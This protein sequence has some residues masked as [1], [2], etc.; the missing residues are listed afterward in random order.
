MK[1]DLHSLVTL[2]AGDHLK[3]SLEQ[4]I[5]NTLSFLCSI[6]GVLSV[7]Q[8]L[9]LKLDPM[10]VIL[11]AVGMVLLTTY[12]ILSRIKKIFKPLVWPLIL[13]STILI[14]AIW[15]YN[16]GSWGA[17]LLLFMVMM[18]FFVVITNG[19][20][21]VIAVIWTMAVPLF[22]LYLEYLHP[23]I[24]IS[25]ESPQVRYFDLASTF[26]IVMGILGVGTAQILT[27][28]RRER[29]KTEDQ[30]E[31]LS[32][33]NQEMSRELEMAQKIQNQLIPLIHDHSNIGFYYKPMEMVGGDFF[34][35]IELSE[36]E[37]GIFLSDV[38]GHGVPAAF[39]TSM[40]KS[41]IMQLDE[42]QKDPAAMLNHLNQA[43]K[44]ITANH[45]VTAFYGVYNKKTR[46]FVY[47]NAGHPSPLIISSDFIISLIMPGKGYPLAL[48]DDSMI[49]SLDKKITNNRVI[50]EKGTKLL[51]FTDGFLEAVNQNEKQTLSSEHIHDFEEMMLEEVLLAHQDMSSQALIDRLMEELVRFR[52]ADFFDDD[53]CLICLDI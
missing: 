9:V 27:N 7:I 37:L 6:F 40:I 20:S 31:L 2:I 44:D 5:F 3:Y 23:E 46:E 39:I 25:Y 15:F 32:K 8:N 53:I 18:F 36:D 48:F 43:L 19:T 14:A 1:K 12:Y 4:R 33:K 10:T 16:G 29:K 34:D 26:I 11:A 24:D 52:G 41:H 35:F 49:Q 38:S 22:M 45:F 47:A 13:T 42:V 21:R 51:M 50:L 28:Y 17:S 30:A